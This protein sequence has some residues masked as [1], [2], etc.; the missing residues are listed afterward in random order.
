MQFRLKY[1]NLPLKLGEKLIP[2]PGW[3]L[4]SRS[5]CMCCPWWEACCLSWSLITNNLEMWIE[6]GIVS[7]GSR[8]C[9][10]WKQSFKVGHNSYRIVSVVIIFLFKLSQKPSKFLDLGW[11]L[12]FEHIFQFHPEPWIFGVHSSLQALS[13]AYQV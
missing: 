5:S 4:W 7:S 6:L 12:N 13:C 1:Q 8:N 9:E 10:A 3:C 11:F 2:V